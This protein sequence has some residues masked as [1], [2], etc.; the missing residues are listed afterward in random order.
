MP[1]A[2]SL[3]APYFLVAALPVVVTSNAVR[4]RPPWCMPVYWTFVGHRPQN[5]C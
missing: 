1:P 5:V 4:T 3:L 2:T